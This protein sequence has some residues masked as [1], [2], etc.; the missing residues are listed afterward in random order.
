MLSGFIPYL[1]SLP[2]VTEVKLHKKVPASSAL[3]QNWEAQNHQL[4]EDFKRFLLVTDGLM[5]LW[6]AQ[7][8]SEPML[9]GKIDI[10]SLEQLTPFVT[11]E[12]KR[13]WSHGPDNCSASYILEDCEPYGKVCLCYTKTNETQIWFYASHEQMWFMIANDFSGY[14][15]LMISCCGILGWQLGY[16]SRWPA[17]TANW[18]QFYSP[19]MAGL[20]REHRCS[21]RKERVEKKR[22]TINSI[23]FS[24]EKVLK[25]LQV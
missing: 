23:S 14:Y 4:P 9:V 22:E 8:K 10:N 2:H 19:G 6:S 18:M 25:S 11:S 24:L 16:G 21:P 17:W 15:R 20:I 1:E 5:V 7:I 13:I 12:D 3:I